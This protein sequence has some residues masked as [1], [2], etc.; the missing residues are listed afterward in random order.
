[1]SRWLSIALMLCWSPWG[2]TTVIAQGPPETVPKKVT[3]LLS[4]LDKNKDDSLDEA[5][6]VAGFADKKLATRDFRLCDWDSDGKLS[7]TELWT[8]PIVTSWEQRGPVPH[9]VT[10]LVDSYFGMLVKRWPVLSEKGGAA[11]PRDEFLKAAAASFNVLTVPTPT[12]DVDVDGNGSISATEARRYVEILLGVRR[13]DGRLLIHPH[14]MVA[15][16]GHFS[17]VDQ[18]QDDRI[19]LSEFKS[20]GGTGEAFIEIF[21]SLDLDKDTQVRF[22]EA[23]KTTRFLKDVVWDFRR[24]DTDFD[25]VISRDEFNAGLPVWQ[26]IYTSYFFSAFDSNSDDKLS[27][28]EFQMSFLGLPVYNW[29]EMISVKND[30]QKLHFKDFRFGNRSDYPL[31][32]WELFRLL[33]RNKD[34]VLDDDEFTF[35]AAVPNAFYTLSAD[36]Q[37]W[38]KLYQMP[39]IK[40]VGSP[41]VSPDGKRLLFDAYGD[42]LADNTLFVVDMDGANLKSLG[43]GMMPNWSA[44]GSM[45]TASLSRGDP[46]G[47]WLLK[48]DGTR[49][50]HIATGWGAQWSPDGKKIAFTDA[51]NNSAILKVYDVDSQR[52]SEVMGA[53]N[54]PYQQVMWNACWSPDSTQICFKGVRPDKREELAIVNAAGAELGFKVRYVGVSIT[55][56]IAW[57]P[58]GDRVVFP[59][60]CPERGRIQLYEFNP[61]NNDAPKLVPGQN[62]KLDCKA[63]TWFPD[64][65]KLVVPA[66]VN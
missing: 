47:V 37:E 44:D 20:R 39:N 29:H 21:N 41:S 30:D 2:A 12:T 49:E 8:V 28:P 52:I 45:F 13:N 40:N 46:Y 36:G 25:A 48:P 43:S 10:K 26:K 14:G 61:E 18:N 59:M 38:K 32:R 17:Y 56:D 7:V 58:R 11:V 50:K 64:G 27:F 15:N 62:P 3:D 34:G 53:E 22:D 65:S 57:H 54:N 24:F 33:D 4:K 6:F 51:I 1:M 42:E 23:T 63:C 55:T 60:Q 19:N 66:G 31:L 9:P 35:K 5:E 16:Y